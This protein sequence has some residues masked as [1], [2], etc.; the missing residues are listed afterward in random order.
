[1]NIIKQKIKIFEFSDRSIDVILLFLAARVSIIIER[2]YHIK[3]WGG[4]D[5]KSFNFLAMPI[6]F[7]VWLILSTIL[8]AKPLRIPIVFHQFIASLAG[9]VKRMPS[10]VSLS[11]SS[12][13]PKSWLNGDSLLSVFWF[14]DSKTCRPIL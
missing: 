6:M 10:G 2:I 11:T 13:N 8:S 7:V 14:V 4:L 9:R 5:E 3:T 1:M 12:D